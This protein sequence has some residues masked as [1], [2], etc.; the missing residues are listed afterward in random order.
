MTEYSTNIGFDLSKHK[1][2]GTVLALYNLLLLY[3]WYK[4]GIDVW[5]FDLVVI[6]INIGIVV[7]YF[8]LYLVVK[9]FGSQFEK[10]DPNDPN[11][12]GG[13]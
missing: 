2:L 6:Y 11:D 7:V 13:F 1:F 9:F 3:L 12:K 4:D 10:R 5:I 8:V